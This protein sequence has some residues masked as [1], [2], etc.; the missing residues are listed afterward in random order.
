MTAMITQQLACI[1]IAGDLE[2][3]V[4]YD[5]VLQMAYLCYNI[6]EVTALPW[7]CIVVIDLTTHYMQN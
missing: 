5:T 1:L 6:N 7:H 3:M 2:F 4:K